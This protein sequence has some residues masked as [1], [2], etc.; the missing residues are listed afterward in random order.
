MNKQLLKRLIVLLI[1]ALCLALLCSCAEVNNSSGEN[2][3][4]GE[5]TADT[6]QDNSGIDEGTE[7]SGSGNENSNT[8]DNKVED[9]TTEEI[10]LPQ[11][12]PED[13][14]FFLRFGTFGCSSYDS[15]TGRLVKTSTVIER[16]PEDYIATYVMSE[17]QL[18]E[19][20][21][22]IRESDILNI[23]RE[24]N[25]NDFVMADPYCTVS[26][27]VSYGEISK[28][29]SADGIAGLS[30][31]YALTE[32]AKIYN[33]TVSYIVDRLLETDEWKA[34]PDYEFKYY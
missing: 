25:D 13:F 6:E 1:L 18:K 27:T 11:Q 7:N 2:N 29:V 15:K 34:L 17:E 20:Y 4:T 3:N 19:L 26:L 8:D 10:I 24:F 12:M 22:K 33:S 9:S 14:S 21:E 5:N 28:I 23:E 32:E 16:E 31:S 30:L